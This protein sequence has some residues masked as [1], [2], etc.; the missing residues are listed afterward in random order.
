MWNHNNKGSMELKKKLNPDDVRCK[1]NSVVV[2]DELGTTVKYYPKFQ[3]VVSLI[4]R[5]E[6]LEVVQFWMQRVDIEHVVSVCMGEIEFEKHNLTLIGIET[7]FR[8][9]GVS[10]ITLIFE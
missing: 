5:E 8:H 7:D 9:Q 6:Y 3:I 10:A 2:H 1:I 4:I